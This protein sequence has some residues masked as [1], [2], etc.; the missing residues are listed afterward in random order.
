MRSSALAAI[1]LA[2]ASVGSALA[3]P[4]FADDAACIAAS[5]Q[6]IP[7]RRQ[8][9]LHD[10]LKRVAACAAPEC[11]AEVRAECSQR[12]EAIKREMPTLV[13]EAKDGAGNDLSAVKVGL[14]GAPLADT[15]DG[16]PLAI[17][18]GEH[19]FTFEIPG[20]APLEKKLVLRQGEKD[21]RESIAFAAAATPS[22][23]T[24]GRTLGAVSAGLGLVGVGVGVA[25]GLFASSSQRRERAD[26]S[27]SAC[28]SYPLAVEDYGTAQSQAT[29]ATI[30]FVA[31][32]ALVAAGVVLWLTAPRGSG[33][34]AAS[35]LRITVAPALVGRGRGL[36]LGVEL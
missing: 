15:L 21:R 36:V 13:L 7:L 1:V 34:P 29:G 4:A 30:A 16:R 9:K 18:P 32:P 17:D 10:A 14:D 31:G 6:A 20:Q 19:T 27:P 26:C 8:G 22:F 3:S 11:P 5:E 24:T 35:A 33:A 25:L 2:T 28:F 23:W 12:I